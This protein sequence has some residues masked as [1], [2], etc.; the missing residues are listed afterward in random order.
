MS[1][2]CSVSDFGHNGSGEKKRKIIVRL[3]LENKAKTS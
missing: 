2:R 3:L 1:V